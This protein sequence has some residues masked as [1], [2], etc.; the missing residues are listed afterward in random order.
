MKKICLL[1]AATS[2]VAVS[3]TAQTQR[4]NRTNSRSH[5]PKDTTRKMEQ[6]TDADKN[7]PTNNT[8][9]ASTKPEHTNNPNINNNVR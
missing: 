9:P 7:N 3:L 4:T 1:I 6:Q 5:Y 2:L 8:N